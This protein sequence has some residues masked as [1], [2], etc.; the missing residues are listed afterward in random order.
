[1]RTTS[2][3]DNMLMSSTAKREETGLREG[4]TCVKMSPFFFYPTALSKD[5]Y[6]PDHKSSF[7]QTL[8]CLKYFF[9]N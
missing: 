9:K 6:I 4:E 2:W 7:L 8:I 3:E 5:F 1:M